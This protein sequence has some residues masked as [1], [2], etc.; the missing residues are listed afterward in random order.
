MIHEVGNGP[1]AKLGKNVDHSKKFY[2]I[3]FLFIQFRLRFIIADDLK[4]IIQ[5]FDSC[6]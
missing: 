6:T 5:T 2:F 4:V 1:E 3:H